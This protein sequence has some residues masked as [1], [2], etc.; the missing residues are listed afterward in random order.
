MGQSLFPLR[1]SLGIANK[2][3]D[4]RPEGCDRIV[5]G[6]K[7]SVPIFPL[8]SAV[9]PDFA[10]ASFCFPYA[11]K[12]P[13]TNPSREEVNQAVA[14]CRGGEKWDRAFFPYAARWA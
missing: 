5:E 7:G 4:W 10:T 14:K 12:R 3:V 1:R 6:E 9:S 11:I 2:A 8:Q 13:S